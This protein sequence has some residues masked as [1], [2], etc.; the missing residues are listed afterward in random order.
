MSRVAKRQ[1]KIKLPLFITSAS[2]LTQDKHV[3][4]AGIRAFSGPRSHTRPTDTRSKI[5]ERQ[6][7]IAPSTSS[8]PPPEGKEDIAAPLRWMRGEEV[9]RPQ[10]DPLTVAAAGNQPQGKKYTRAVQGRGWPSV[11]FLDP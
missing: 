10:D 7:V 6:S 2:T 1:I 3:I 8:P 11:P 9:T 4:I 5:E